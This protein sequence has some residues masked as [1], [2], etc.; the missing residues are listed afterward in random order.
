VSEY[1]G[2]QYVGIDLHRMRS[3]I[4]R[5]I[6]DGTQLSAVRVLNDP[7]ALG[8]CRSRGQAS[9]PTWCGRPPTAGDHGLEWCN[10]RTETAVMM[11]PLSTAHRPVNSQGISVSPTPNSPT[12]ARSSARTEAVKL[13]P[14][15]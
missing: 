4:M 9:A 8:L 10:R 12:A 5:Q 1:D 11:N 7:V 6:A 14:W 2:R 3:V 13:R 15:G